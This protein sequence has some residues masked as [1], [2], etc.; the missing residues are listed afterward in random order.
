MKNELIKKAGNLFNTCS[1]RIKQHSP[2]ILMGLGIV[3][4]VT[5]AIMACRETLKVSNVIDEAKKNVDAVHTATELPDVDYTEEDATK[6]LT[7]IY[8]Q[9]GVKLIKLYAPSVILGALSI[10]SIV[11][12]HKILKTRNLALA[13]AYTTL[14]K[15]FKKYRSNVVERFGEAVDKE[16]KYNTKIKEIETV[17]EKGKKKKEKV[18]EI[19]TDYVSQY[20]PYARFFDELS[21]DYRKDAE[22]NLMFLRRVQDWANEKLRAR[23][24]YDKKTGK[25]KKPG[26]VFLNEV[27][28]D[29]DIPRSKA[30]QIVGWVYNPDNNPVGDNYIDFGIYNS[31]S[32]RFVNG[33]EKG[34]LLDFN[35]DGPIDYILDNE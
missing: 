11:S 17:N 19:D 25:V 16:L 8:A 35:V 9:T 10:T 23:V 1:F 2:E 4:T 3:G 14:E 31:N 5:S 15:G 34:I 20:S 21:R 32:H 33:V 12:G 24:V 30:G 28:D 7:I 6:D 29:L 27:Y 13:A 26:Y 22:Y 18:E